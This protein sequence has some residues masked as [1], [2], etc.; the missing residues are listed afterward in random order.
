MPNSNERL[1]AS[2]LGQ[3]FVDES[4][5][6]TR[7]ALTAVMERFNL[8]DVSRTPEPSR[9]SGIQSSIALSQQEEWRSYPPSYQR[10]AFQEE[11]VGQSISDVVLKLSE[12]LALLETKVTNQNETIEYLREIINDK[13]K[14]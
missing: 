14:E 8:P 2:N 7:E 3:V 4:A 11:S 9:P 10:A 12:Q 13:F 5:T 1:S 6:L